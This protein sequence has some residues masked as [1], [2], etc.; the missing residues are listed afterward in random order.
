M[1]TVWQPKKIPPDSTE[2]SSPSF[3]QYSHDLNTGKIQLDCRF[4]SHISF[5]FFHVVF[6]RSEVSLLRSIHQFNYALI[7]SLICNC[8]ICHT[9]T[10]LC[11]YK[12]VPKRERTF[13]K[14]LITRRSLRDVPICFHV[15]RESTRLLASASGGA[16]FPQV[17][18]G[19]NIKRRGTRTQSK[20]PHVQLNPFVLLVPSYFP[21]VYVN[22]ARFSGCGKLGSSPSLHAR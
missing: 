17:A 21:P 12:S 19:P 6:L 9:S 5:S 8:L 4:A 7:T 13:S 3:R 18:D 16:I 11:S 15:I 2:V 1:C 20:I 14:S 22:D 10:T